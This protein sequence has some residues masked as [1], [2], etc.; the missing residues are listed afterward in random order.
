MKNLATSITTIITLTVL[1]FFIDITTPGEVEVG[2]AY[3]IPAILASRLTRAGYVYILTAFFSFPLIFGFM[4][5]PPQV[6]PEIA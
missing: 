5:S 3:I 4:F 6:Q 1:I 2:M